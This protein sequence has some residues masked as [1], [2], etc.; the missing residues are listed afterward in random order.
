M[1]Y[2]HVNA[3]CDDNGTKPHLIICTLC[4]FSLCK[5]RE[6]M[7]VILR[8]PKPDDTCRDMVAKAVLIS[9][10]RNEAAQHALSL[11]EE[12]CNLNC[13]VYLDVDE[14]KPSIDWQDC[15][16]YAVSNCTIFVPL[17]TP[18]YGKTQWTNRE[19][20]LADVRQKVII[21]V[22]FTEQWPPD[23]LAIQFAST[24]YIPWKF[25]PQEGVDPTRHNQNWKK[26]DRENIHRTAKDIADR[27]MT[28]K[29]EKIPRKV[30][31]KK[32]RGQVNPA[33]HLT[34]LDSPRNNKS[35]IVISIHPKQR[36]IALE[37]SRGLQSEGYTIWC[38]CE[39]HTFTEGEEP[40]SP[41]DLPPI[42]EGDTCL[43]Q[44][45]PASLKES[46][47]GFHHN[48]GSGDFNGSLRQH[49]QLARTI[50]NLSDNHYMST[51]SQ[52]KLAQLKSFQQNVNQAG[53]VVVVTSEDYFRSKFSHQ[54]V[55]YCE[56]RKKVIVVETDGANMPTWFSMLMGQEPSLVYSSTHFLPSLRSRIKKAL[57]PGVTES[58]TDTVTEAKLQCWVNF[59]KTN[60]LSQE[61][62]IYIVG[63]A[64]CNIH[65]RTKEICKALGEEV[66]KIENVTLV[67][68]GFF[69]VPE[70]V[71]RTFSE[72]R[73]TNLPSTIFHV[74]PHRDSQDYTSKA[75]QNP[76]GSFEQLSYGKSIF[77]GDSV[78][79]RD[80]AIAR[81]IDTC[82][83][84]E[85][86]HSKDRIWDTDWLKPQK[87]V[88]QGCILSPYL[89]NLY[90]EHIIRLAD[91]DQIGVHIRRMEINN[92]FTM[93]MTPHC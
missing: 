40:L 60:G 17:I 11:K 32:E 85:G 58:P 62:C 75:P 7:G 43:S 22:N 25:P 70:L 74:L 41:R 55:F 23:C 21:P 1:H 66:A 69:G 80:M 42:P 59:M 14:I 4:R 30:M 12:L 88:R 52:E 6:V 45:L 47:R 92:L 19:V 38:S 31:S 44:E 82:I 26:W 10:V 18:L 57:N 87:G 93:L 81:H 71:G 24:Q 8:R 53:V 50:S 86:S 27:L 76:D 16:N 89:F 61:L 46:I 56:H 15:L 35:L 5:N 77:V 51:I 48:E 36:G 78:K 72:S 65:T 90:T 33:Y 3:V 28:I 2:V 9:Y 91:F 20:K 64:S 54:Q 83:L 29:S 67:T 63:T 73:D 34:E 49:R 39:P 84:I 68:G 13:S 37:L 79:E